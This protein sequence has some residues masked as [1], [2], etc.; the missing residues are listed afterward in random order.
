MAKET[1]LVVDDEEDIL[2]LVRHHLKREGYEVLCADSGEK[3]LMSTR[4]NP[5]DLI[6]LDLMLPGIDGLEVA[7]KLK[8]DPQAKHIPILM[9]SA[10]GEESDV[11]TGLELGADDYVQNQVAEW[12][13]QNLDISIDPGKVRLDDADGLQPRQALM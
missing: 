6:M 2:E 1:I 7:R 10:K 5:V 8:N 4:N 13:Q 9:M 11:V 12:C 3:A